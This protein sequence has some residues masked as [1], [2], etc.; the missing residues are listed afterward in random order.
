MSGAAQSR[1]GFDRAG[2]ALT[3]VM[4]AVLV[5]ARVRVLRNR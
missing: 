5:L 1:I 4:P 3:L 2:A